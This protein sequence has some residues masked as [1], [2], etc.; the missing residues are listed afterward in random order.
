MIP[1]AT[2]SMAV[3]LLSTVPSFG[4]SAQAQT[5]DPGPILDRAVAAY[6]NVTTL[7]AYFTQSI[8]DPMLGSDETSR[9]E[10][11]QQRPNK[12]AMRW[13]RPRGDLILADGQYIW[14]FLPSST[15]NQ[16][17]R[18]ALSSRTGETGDLVAEFLDRPRDRF[19]VAY[20]RAEAVG[21]RAADVLALTPRDRN[22]GYRRVL[23]WVD[24]Q[25][26]LVRQVEITEVSGAVRRITFDRLK[27]NQPIPSST[28]AFRPPAG[29]RV[30]DATH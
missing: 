21:A 28:F 30:V 20:E 26:D 1:L 19:T 23:I 11:I 22:A 27:V 6:G 9:G 18:S 13:S 15:P 17:V 10:F 14:V 5:Q 4:R 8:R 7:R 12:F 24:R 25:D 29:A 3:L 16:V 2:M